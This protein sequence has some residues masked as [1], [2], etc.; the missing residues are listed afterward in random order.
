[1]PRRTNMTQDQAYK[2]LNERNELSQQVVDLREENG[3]LIATKDR[4]L[5]IVGRQNADIRNL[6]E[7]IN[8]QRS[9]LHAQLHAIQALIMLVEVP[10]AP[11][12]DSE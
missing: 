3:A 6:S 2:Y 10:D 9:A 11:V 12:T 8:H 4:L 1:M 7:I 5:R